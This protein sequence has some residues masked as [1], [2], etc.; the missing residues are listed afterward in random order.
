MLRLGGPSVNRNDLQAL[1]LVDNP[2][3]DPLAVLHFDNRQFMNV[4]FVNL[5]PEP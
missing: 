1:T 5:I 2:V 4:P 3:L